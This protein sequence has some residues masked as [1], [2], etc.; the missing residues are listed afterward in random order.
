MPPKEV[1]IPSERDDYEIIPL[2]PL[3]R[4]EKRLETI[5]TTKSMSHLERFIDKIIDMV[6]LNQKIVDEVIGAN[7][8]LREDISIL[9]SK[10]DDSQ[11]KMSEFI[12]IIK[13][14]G[15]QE[16]GEALSKELIDGVVKPLVDKIEIATNKSAESTTMMADTLAAIEKRM[17]AVQLG[18]QSA[19]ARGAA[20]ILQRRRPMP[21]NAPPPL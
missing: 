12:E 7:Q 9:I 16:S 2:S 20:S 4:L 14:A 8:G 1:E 17:K 3:R 10:I 13:E 6:E 18:N 11:S 19:P 21:Q 15:E 5:E